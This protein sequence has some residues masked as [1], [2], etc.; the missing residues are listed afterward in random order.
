MTT[1]PNDSR[2]REVFEREYFADAGADAWPQ[3]R[4]R[5]DCGT[6]MDRH[7]QVAWTNFRYGWLAAMREGA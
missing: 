3:A 4:E 1:K 5:H 7:T 2:C 6:Y